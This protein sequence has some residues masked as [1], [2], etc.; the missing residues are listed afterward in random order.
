MEIFVLIN[1]SVSNA[2]FLYPLK[3]SENLKVLWCFQRVEK[4]FIGN[5]YV[6]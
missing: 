4:G 3:T 6:N 1:Q 2:P 5:E